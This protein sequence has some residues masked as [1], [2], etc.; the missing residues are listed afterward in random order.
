MDQYLIINTLEP[1]YI[2]LETLSTK[3]KTEKIDIGATEGAEETRDLPPLRGKIPAENIFS[4]Y[5]AED[6]L[7]PLIASDEILSYVGLVWIFIIIA[8]CVSVCVCVR[9]CARVCVYVHVC[10]RL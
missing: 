7:D 6:H 3:W 9:A 4:Y 8:A 10:A 2:I 1:L 5:E